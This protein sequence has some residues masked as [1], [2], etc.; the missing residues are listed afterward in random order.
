MFKDKYTVLGVMSGTSLDGIDIAIVHFTKNLDK[1]NYHIKRATTIAYPS[2]W[3]NKLS[4]AANLSFKEIDS[5]NINYTHFL[6]KVIQSF[7]EKEKANVDAVCSHG[8]TVLHQPEKGFT[9]QIGNLPILKNYISC[10]IVCDFRVQDVLLG[11]QG[12]PLV[13]IGDKLLF[14]RYEHCLNLGGFSNISFDE[15]DKRIAFDICPVN[16]VLN[17]YANKMGF[18]YDD[19]GQIAASGILNEG[20]YNSLNQDIYYKKSYPK[21]LGIEFVNENVFPVI[22]SFS[23]PIA[24]ILHTYC[25]HIAHQITEVLNKKTGDVL[26]TGGGVFNDFLIELIKQRQTTTKLV[27][28][29]D[30]TISYKEAI[31]FAFLGILKLREEINVLSS[32]TGASRDHSSGVIF[33]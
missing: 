12:A 15:N 32:V 20:L 26:V 17:F 11:G 29:E 18:A 19:K 13:P 24:S 7:L 8:H 30:D 27:I 4:T 22:N 6:G 23:L 28:P 21:S 14:T 1:W 33:R 25:Q 2:H 9:I 31:I 3:L 5:L 16:T 10:P